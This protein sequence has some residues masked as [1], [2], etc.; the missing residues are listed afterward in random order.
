MGYDHNAIRG[1]HLTHKNDQTYYKINGDI[2]E[3]IHQKTETGNRIIKNEKKK[4]EM[5]KEREKKRREK[6][7]KERFIADYRPIHKWA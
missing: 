3:Y 6:K 7:L 1:K 2:T 5:E 4:G